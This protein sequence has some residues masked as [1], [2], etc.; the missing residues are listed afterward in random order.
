MLGTPLKQMVKQ[1]VSADERQLMK[2]L[3]LEHCHIDIAGRK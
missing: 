2:D 3:H 1:I